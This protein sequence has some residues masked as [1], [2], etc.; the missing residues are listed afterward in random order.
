MCDT[1]DNTVYR[2][3]H[4]IQK[5]RRQVLLLRHYC[6]C[7]HNNII[8]FYFLFRA[9]CDDAKNEVIQHCQNMLR[10]EIAHARNILRRKGVSTFFKPSHLQQIVAVGSITNALYISSHKSLC[11]NIII[12][13][14]KNTASM[15]LPT[16]EKSS[17]NSVWNVV[18][19]SAK[20]V[21][22]FIRLLARLGL[23]GLYFTPAAV[24][25]PLLLTGS[26]SVKD[27]W[28]ELIRCA[29]FA[30]GP[31]L[32]KFAQ[33]AATRP[34]IF[35]SKFCKELEFLQ[36]QSYQ[37]S[38][39]AT[40]SLLQKVYGRD[41]HLR[42]KLDQESVSGSGL[43]AQ[44]YH[45]YLLNDKQEPVQEVAVKVLH[46]G[47]KAA[48]FEDLALLRYIAHTT[49][50]LARLVSWLWRAG[51]SGEHDNI[52]RESVLETTISLSES[53][54]EF[55][56]LMR[57]QLDL[58]RE[59]EAMVRFRRNFSSSKYKDRVMFAEPVRWPGE[60]MDTERSHDVLIETFMRGQPMAE[61]LG[62]R[63]GKPSQR[64][65]DLAKLGLDI[66]LKMVGI[67]MSKI[68]FIQIVDILLCSALQIFEDNFIHGDLHPGNLL[69]NGGLN[70]AGRLTVLDTG[71]YT[72]LKAQD[73]KNLLLLFKAVLDRDGSQVGRLIVEKSRCR[74]SQQRVI[75]P[76]GFQIAMQA[77]IDDAFRQGL[78]PENRGIS[79]LL[80][81]VLQLC[82]KH[83]V[84]L[85]T[86]FASVILS[87]GVVEGLGMQL[88]PSI[89]ILERAGPFILRAAARDYG[90]I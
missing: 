44:V 1:I 24:A 37:H 65:R 2:T 20:W 39:N 85:E 78:T 76:E 51:A 63:Q 18:K 30:S 25:S 53:V 88:D 31:C 29:I 72:E 50:D 23:L 57:A 69:L 83:R 68:V 89:D 8:T 7:T 54:D 77:V 13:S 14:G 64:E 81:R 82:Y 26:D 40:D 61:F 12:S 73:R 9:L 47:V 67:V 34:D 43:V 16:V 46:P 11:E 6:Y 60:I 75:D 3:R 49:E 71:L 66:I 15:P 4:I 55:S 17:D 41:W 80:T 35:N 27:G 45:G 33:W 10:V 74:R 48:M 59:G 22:D 86:G 90:L 52:N 70:E 19:K 5:K 79:N 32:T 62:K 38:W 42:M 84:R 21:V 87:V 56:E 36:A 58:K 28:W